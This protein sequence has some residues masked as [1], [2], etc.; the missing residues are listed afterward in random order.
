MVANFSSS[1]QKR[2]EIFWVLYT[3]RE[4][5]SELQYTGQDP[6]NTVSQTDAAVNDELPSETPSNS[7]RFC[8]WLLL[9]K[10]MKCPQLFIFPEILYCLF[11]VSALR[12]LA[13][14]RK[15]NWM[16]N[17]TKRI[18]WMATRSLL[19]SRHKTIPHKLSLESSSSRANVLP[20]PEPSFISQYSYRIVLY[21]CQ[22]PDDLSLY[23]SIM[24]T[25]LIF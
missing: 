6:Q 5:D 10:E 17:V 4:N 18:W 13:E 8:Y 22:S 19:M 11:I 12:W 9:S 3:V 14:E 7:N 1:V 15:G 24:A 2:G 23:I 20:L 25:Y 16:Y 21:M